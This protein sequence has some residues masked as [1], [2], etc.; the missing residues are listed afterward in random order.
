MNKKAIVSL[1]VLS[2]VLVACG[3]TTDDAAEEVVEQTS[4]EVAEVVTLSSLI[5]IGLDG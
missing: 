5:K 1:L 3:D 2:M 4:E